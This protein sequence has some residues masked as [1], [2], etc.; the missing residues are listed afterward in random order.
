MTVIFVRGRDY[1]LK[2]YSSLRGPMFVDKQIFAGSWGRYFPNKI[3]FN[4]IK[5]NKKCN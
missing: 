1:I 3:K 5:L 2:N 4:R